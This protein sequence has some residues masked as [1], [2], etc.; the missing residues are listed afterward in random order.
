[1]E[2]ADFAEHVEKLPKPEILNSHAQNTQADP[3]ELWK[4]AKENLRLI[5]G[6]KVFGGIFGG[7]YI[8][9]IQNGLVQISC[10]ASYKREKI[11][12]DYKATLKRAL[13]K[14]SGRN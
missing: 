4:S 2:K 8:E 9:N 6:P 10:D 1:M 14:S 5:I 12:R 11:L 13:L 3:D 7:C